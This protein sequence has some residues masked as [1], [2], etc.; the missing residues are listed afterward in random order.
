MRFEKV[1]FVYLIVIN[2]ITFIIYGIDK[3]RARNHAWRIPE[4]T[5]LSMAALGG[6]VGALAGMGY[7]HHKTRHRK[8]TAGVPS[9]LAVHIIL[10]I[11]ILAEP[12][13]ASANYKVTDTS[14]KVY[15]YAGLMT[16]EQGNSLETYADRLS[17]RYGVDFVVVTITENNRVSAQDFADRF[18]DDNYF[19]QKSGKREYGKGDGMLFLID[20]QNRDIALSTAGLLHRAMGDEEVDQLLDDAVGYMRSESYYEACKSALGNSAGAVDGYISSRNVMSIVVPVILAALLT[21]VTLGILVSFSKKSKPATE[22]GRFIVPNSLDI[23]HQNEIRTGTYTSVTPI[24]KSTQ[25]GGGGGGGSHTSS[26]G[27]SHGGGSRGF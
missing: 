19:G 7:F 6:S 25:S 5:L 20:M 15:D 11:L 26:G 4:H 22:A 10:L 8:F 27:A 21:A 1:L 12:V 18:F 9:F 24:P 17:E 2:M 14:R 13:S 16:E 3:R 23:R